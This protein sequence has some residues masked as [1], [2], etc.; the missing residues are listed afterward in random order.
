MQTIVVGIPLIEPFGFLKLSSLV[1]HYILTKDPALFWSKENREERNKVF[2]YLT[3]ESRYNQENNPNKLRLKSNLQ[4]RPLTKPIS[5]A[6]NQLLGSF[7]CVDGANDC[8]A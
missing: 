6:Q 7:N 3:G 2:Y 5:T 4:T 8:A 1:G